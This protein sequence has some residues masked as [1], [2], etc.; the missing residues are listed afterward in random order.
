MDKIKLAAWSKPGAYTLQFTYFS[1]INNDI[2]ILQ[3]ASLQSY[4]SNLH[5]GIHSILNSRTNVSHIQERNIPVLQV[6]QNEQIK[7]L[8]RDPCSLFIILGT[9]SN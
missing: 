3:F 7:N 6:I 2:L 1:K 5:R 4:F 9:V 8:A